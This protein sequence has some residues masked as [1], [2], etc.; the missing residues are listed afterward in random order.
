VSVGVCA[1]RHGFADAGAL[2]N[3]AER[4][5]REAR[6]RE[7]GVHRFEPPKRIEDE[8]AA[9]LTIAIRAAV[10]HDGFE[11][12]YQPIVAL[13][14]GEE[15][16]YQTL[17]RLRD[18][19]GRLHTAAEIVPLAARANLIVEVDRWVL[20]HSLRVLEQRRAE[21][22]PVR[23]FVSQAATSLTAP[24]QA[25]WLAAQLQARRL[26][27]HALVIELALD[28]IASRIDAVKD[29]CAATV[30][31][32][33]RFCL[34]RFEGGLEG[35]SVLEQ[36]PVDYIK[37]AS[38]YLA[39]SHTPGLRDELRVIVERGH[40][41]GLSVIAQRVEDAQAA[42]TLWMSGIDY[43]QGNLVQLAENDLEFDFQ[44]AVL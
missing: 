6:G 36:L 15:A 37:L 26:E 10:E 7:R 18:D 31:L 41:R 30:P 8:M 3:A 29:F 34:S 9:A 23:L 5:S 21:H 42:A 39:A 4:A 11:L 22:R 2:L 44:T 43:I 40:R 27:G 35:D 38:K 33:V 16:Q 25:A 24:G 20:T 1:F 12:L 32:G 19:G 14:G 13:Q 17:L 28:D